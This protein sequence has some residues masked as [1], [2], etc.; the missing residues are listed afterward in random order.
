MLNLGFLGIFTLV[1]PIIK[2]YS[3]T[4]KGELCV[5]G[6]KGNSLVFSN[7]FVSLM[8]LSLHFK[9]ADIGKGGICWF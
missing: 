8:D 9:I 7:P 1:F 6:Y 3:L 2:A 4:N 5:L